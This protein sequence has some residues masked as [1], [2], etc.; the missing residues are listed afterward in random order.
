MKT[1]H[2]VAFVLL[3]VGGV[4]WGLIAIGGLLGYNFNLVNILFGSWPILE[5]LTYLLVGIAAVYIG[6]THAKHCSACSSARSL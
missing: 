6:I 3:I 1:L 2:I 5:G 4:N